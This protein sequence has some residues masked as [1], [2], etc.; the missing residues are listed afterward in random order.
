M[1]ADFT[2]PAPGLR[3]TDLINA[4]TS[5]ASALSPAKARAKTAAQNFEAVFLNTMFQ[6]MFTDIDGEGPFGGGPATGIWRSL[7]TDE[8]AKNFSKSGGIG[9]ANQVYKTLIAQQEIKQ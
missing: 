1:N 2:L 3:P 9:I 4:N 6:Q 5:A 7:L 8:Y